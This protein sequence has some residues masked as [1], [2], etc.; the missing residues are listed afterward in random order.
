MQVAICGLGRMGA[1]MARRAAQGG[2]DVV[3]WNRT[4]SVASEVAAEPERLRLQQRPG[5]R[6]LQRHLCDHAEGVYGI[7][8]RRGAAEPPIR[9][10]FIFGSAFPVAS[11]CWNIASQTVGTPAEC[12]TPSRVI[13]SLSTAGSLT[14]E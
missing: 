10:C 7:K 12:V 11:A 9:A 14:A 13:R 3:V 2:H 4:E 6:H 8:A 5:L 1:G